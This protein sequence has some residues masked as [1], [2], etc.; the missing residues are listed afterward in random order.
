MTARPGAAKAASLNASAEGD[1]RGRAQRRQGTEALAREQ[2]VGAIEA[3]RCGDL[4][5]V[6][7]DALK[8]IRLLARPAVVIKG[9][10]RVK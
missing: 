8:N 7:G 2:D 1:P 10:G 9:G 4:V 3:G 6:A 5:A